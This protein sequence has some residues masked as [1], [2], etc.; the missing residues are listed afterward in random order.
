MCCSCGTCYINLHS[1]YIVHN[2]YCMQFNIYTYKNNISWVGVKGVRIMD[3][4]RKRD[5]KLSDYNISK[6]KY[7]ELKYFC[8]QYNE[9]KS[10]LSSSYGLNA[11]ANDGMPKGNTV[12]NPTER[13]AIRNEQ[14]KKDIEIIESTSKEA[15]PEISEYILQNVTEGI[16][17]DYLSVPLSRTKFYDA[18][19]YFFFLLAQKK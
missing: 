4:V 7:N 9:K 14:L 2:A 12:G 13:I 5:I 8:M 1:C 3:K 16:P 15:D 19:R 18:R 11:V 17:Y 6:A 10:E